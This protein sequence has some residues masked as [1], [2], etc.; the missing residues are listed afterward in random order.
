MEQEKEA[1]LISG[2]FT[3]RLV[4]WILQDMGPLIK[5]Q[6]KQTTIV[7]S[8]SATWIH[9]QTGEDEVYQPEHQLMKTVP[10]Y[11]AVHRLMFAFSS[12]CE[13]RRSLLLSLTFSLPFP[14][15]CM[16]LPLFVTRPP[17][18]ILAAWLYNRHLETCS[19]RNLLGS[20]LKTY[21]QNIML[22][23]KFMWW[24][25]SRYDTLEEWISVQVNWLLIGMTWLGNNICISAC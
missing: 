11:H 16:S 5:D 6:Y 24:H 10:F 21:F 22:W 14:F 7:I 1:F 15:V 19:V 12:N 13:N 3:D 9:P 23:L 20:H 25:N 8:G 4:K 2:Q 18:L 17:F